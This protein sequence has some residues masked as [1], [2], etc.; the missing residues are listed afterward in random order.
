MKFSIITVSFNSSTTIEKTIKSVL[1]QNYP[2]LEYIIIDGASTDG[3]MDIINRYK[4]NISRIVSEKDSGIYNAM[5]KGISLANGDIIGIINSDDWYDEN[6]V[7]KVAESFEENTQVIYGNLVYVDSEGKYQQNLKL[8][9][10]ALNYTMAVPHPTVFIRKEVYKKYGTFN[11]NY[12]IASDYELILRLYKKHVNIQYIDS[13]IAYFRTGGTS[14]LNN[15]LCIQETKDIAIK[16][17]NVNSVYAADIGLRYLSS[18]FKEKDDFDI[19]NGELKIIKNK[20]SDFLRADYR[21]I[22][23][24]TGEWCRICTALL[25]SYSI[26]VKYYIDNDPQKWDTEFLGRTI[27][28]P[29]YVGNEMDSKIIVATIKYQDEIL[30]QLIDLGLVQQK[31]FISFKQLAASIVEGRNRY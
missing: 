16:Y 13:T 5:N 8:P 22:V 24:G 25:D 23:F 21:V 20:I 31:D 12:K 18:L 30:K 6:A 29:A 10:E 15:M 28:A 11:E 17:S 9:L 2:E 7:K 14:S 26:K 19:I 27:K 3:T 1:N 4:N